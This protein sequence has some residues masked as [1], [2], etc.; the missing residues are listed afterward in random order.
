MSEIEHSLNRKPLAISLRSTRVLLF[1]NYL[2]FL[3]AI[4]YH[5]MS[6]IRCIKK[7]ESNIYLMFAVAFAIAFYAPL[8][9]LFKGLK[10]N[11]EFRDHFDNVIVSRHVLTI[12]KALVL[13][14][15]CWSLAFA[16]F[17]LDRIDSDM[18]YWTV[19]VAATYLSGVWY[20]TAALEVHRKK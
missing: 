11:P 13:Y 20:H 14:I 9:E 15:V 1:L 8:Y 3:V 4:F 7:D 12:W 5:G 10:V 6:L 18:F 2:G 19:G 16:L 17:S